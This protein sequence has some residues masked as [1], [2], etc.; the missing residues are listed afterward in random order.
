M[1][2]ILFLSGA[3]LSAQSGI[4]T[5]R[6]SGGLWEE[7][8]VME[9]C[10]VAGY[11]KNP[12]KVHSFYDK[13]RAELKDKEPNSA[14]KMIA[15][16]KNRFPNRVSVITQNVDNLLEKAGCKE[17]IHLHGELT[18]LRCL[19]CEQIFYHGY[20]TQDKA[21]CKKC[22]SLNIRHHIVMF[23]EPAPMYK[24][25]YE[26][27]KKTE[28]L[29]CIGTSGEVID[30]A[31]MAMLTKDSILNNIEKI[32]KIDRYFKNLFTMPATE[33]APLIKEYCLDFLKENL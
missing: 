29:V 8:D 14:H 9:V 21:V 12:S 23:G 22:G 19:K 20:E 3:G 25:L 1:G 5:F 26:E 2:K 4:S 6:D 16:L 7:H 28:L 32:P 24:V 27:L 31:S 15:S 13:R 30:V 18:H 17:P 33:A 10:S 11:A